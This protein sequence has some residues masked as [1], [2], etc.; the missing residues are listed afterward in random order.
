MLGEGVMWSARDNAVYWV[1]ILGCSINRIFLDNGGIERFAQPDY[2]AWV[3]E[4]AAG[5]LVAGIG[6]SI[7]RLDLP[8][9][10]RELIGNVEPDKHSNRLN[11]AKADWQ[12]RIWAG[13]VPVSCDKPTGSFYRIAPDGAVTLADTPYT[14]A[15][16]PA[17]DPLGRFL[18]LT[19]SALRT[20]FRFEIGD[21]GTLGMRRPFICF[22]ADWGVPDGMTL[23]EEG[24][25]WVACWG[26]G[27]VTRFTSAGRRDRS[28]PLPASQV[29]SCAFAGTELNRMFVTSA[30][31]DAGGKLGGA[32]FEVDPG[33]R[34]LAPSAYRG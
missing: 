3:I 17:I 18:L 30:R 19:D 2:A 8:A 23:D 1:D 21:D 7:Y 26:A 9:N 5:G 31:D 20:I 10:A 6:R 28:I 11:D 13:T 34:G 33:C 4:R 24:G 32:L 25:I 12:G 27:C 16:G 15:N 22:E 14:I 29:T